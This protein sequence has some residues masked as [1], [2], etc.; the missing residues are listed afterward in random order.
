MEVLQRLQMD[1]QGRGAPVRCGI[2][3]IGERLEPG[4]DRAD[5]SAG[6]ELDVGA[7]RLVVGRRMAVVQGQH[8]EFGPA[9]AEDTQ[10]QVGRR[11]QILE[12]R[13]DAHRARRAEPPRLVRRQA[14]E[15]QGHAQLQDLADRRVLAEVLARHLAADDQ[16]IRGLEGR[17]RIAGERGE[18]HQLEQAGIGPADL[19]QGL[20]VSAAH[21]HAADFQP[22]RLL[23]LR[24]VER[25]EMAGGPGHVVGLER[26]LAGEREVL[27]EPEHLLISGDEPVEADLVAQVEADQDCGGEADAQAQDGD[28]GVQPVAGQVSERG[29]DVVAQH[30]E[31]SVSRP[32]C[33]SG[34]RRRRCGAGPSC[35]SGHRR[36]PG[37]PAAGWSAAPPPHGSA[38]G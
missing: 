24:K 10:A 25:Q 8:R 19:L 3:P 23:H 33:G 38:S 17:D 5:L 20:E 6:L 21:A 18:G 12:H 26:L 36:P 30:G 31:L 37:R 7:G 9:G 22:R 15:V 29:Q 32:W 14:G 11:R 35:R 16:T 13:Q 2:A 27:L 4:L 34:C 1:R 28:P